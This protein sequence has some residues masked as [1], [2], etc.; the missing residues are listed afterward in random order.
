MASQEVNAATRRGRDSKA[1]IAIKAQLL[2]ETA[3]PGPK[4]KHGSGGA[5]AKS[6][7]HG[8]D[9]SSRL[10]VRA[11]DGIMMEEREE[12]NKNA[13]GWMAKESQPG[14]CD[15]SQPHLWH[16]GHMYPRL[17]FHTIP[18]TRRK[19]A[20]LMLA[21]DEATCFW[22]VAGWAGC[23]EAELVPI[24]RGRNTGRE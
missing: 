12:E 10:D 3:C 15:T 9:V 22:D 5:K 21:P 20:D 11:K 6:R 16:T 4:P 23:G 7:K 24:G 8:Q 13:A 2:R 14:P 1:V 19:A 17:E 18:P